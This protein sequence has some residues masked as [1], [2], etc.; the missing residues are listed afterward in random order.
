[1]KFIKINKWNKTDTI[2][3]IVI[4][5]MIV[6][7]WS[8]SRFAALNQVFWKESNPLLVGVT[9]TPLKVDLYMVFCLIGNIIVAYLL[10]KKWRRGWQVITL[11]ALFYCVFWAFYDGVGVNFS[12]SDIESYN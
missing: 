3:Q 9:N 5:I 8:Q 1:M 10:P 12:F 7:N 6:F 2:W 11:L 4:T